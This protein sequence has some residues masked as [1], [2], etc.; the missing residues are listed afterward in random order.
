MRNYIVDLPI[1][2]HD[3]SEIQQSYRP[4]IMDGR[5]MT[6]RKDRRP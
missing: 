2:G 4:V 6:A 1:H 5:A 3:H